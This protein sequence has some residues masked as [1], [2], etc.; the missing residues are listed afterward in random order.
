[1]KTFPGIP[2]AQQPQTTQ[3]APPAQVDSGG[4]DSAKENKENSDGPKTPKT[5]K[6]KKGEEQSDL[7]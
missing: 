2:Q 3:Q 1:M 5:R 6:G 4:D 7:L